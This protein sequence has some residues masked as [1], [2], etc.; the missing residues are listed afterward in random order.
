VGGFGRGE[1][2]GV[3]FGVGLEGGGA[4]GAWLLGVVSMFWW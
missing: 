4:E 1:G 3:F 2:F